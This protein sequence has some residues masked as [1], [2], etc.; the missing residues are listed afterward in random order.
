MYQSKLRKVQLNAQSGGS[1]TVRKH[2][3][4][5]DGTSVQFPVDSAQQAE[6]QLLFQLVYV[7]TTNTFKKRTD[8]LTVTCESHG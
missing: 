7:H 6:T 2:N 3:L 5:A 1:D 8:F 4:A